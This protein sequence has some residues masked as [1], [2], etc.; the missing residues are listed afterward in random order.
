MVIKDEKD[1]IR[2]IKE[3]EWMM[4]ILRAVKSL[5]LPDW[6]VCA[7]FV[8]SKIWDVLHGFKERTPIPDVDVIYF[9][10]TNTEEAEEKK[11]ETRLRNILPNIP[12]SVKNEA[13]MHVVNNIP[14]YSS[15]VDAISKFPETATSLGV[16]LD[17][18]D[19]IILVAPWGVEDVIN[20]EV[21]PTPYFKESKERAQIYEER[22]T[23]KNWKDIWYKVNVFHIE[24]PYSISKVRK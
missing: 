22:I 7:G 15:S 17:G 14:P 12:W 2:L 21:K 10:D 3:D 5:N 18:K 6:W 4:D 9:D 23:K 8:R 13:R 1:I 20:L 24:N 19:K 11:F 16:K